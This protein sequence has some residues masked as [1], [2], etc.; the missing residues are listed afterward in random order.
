MD[1]NAVC[2]PSPFFWGGGDTLCMN[3]SEPVTT[4]VLSVMHVSEGASRGAV[5]RDLLWV[6]AKQT[7]KGGMKCVYHLHSL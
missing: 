4:H 5:G 6:M 7:G 2:Q 1:R 3:S